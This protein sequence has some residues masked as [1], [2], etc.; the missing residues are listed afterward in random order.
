M[1]IKT[2]TGKYEELLVRCKNLEPIP[3]TVA[4]PCEV[5]ALAGALEAGDYGLIK[6]ILVGPIDKIKE[7][8]SSNNL[9]L[10]DVE[11]IDTKHS[12]ESAA[13]AVALVRDGKAELLMKGSLH[14]D[15][16][17]SAVIARDGGLRT[18]RRISH[19]FIMD[20]PTYHKV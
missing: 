13:K 5:S 10:K 1:N 19:V 2:G 6:P 17:M 20:V 7:I 8:A 15:E 4:H 3:T 18:H 11:I 9:D 12:H 14:T 16:L